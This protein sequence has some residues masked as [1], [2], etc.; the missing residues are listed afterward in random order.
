M[1]YRSKR[2]ARRIA[3]KSR[4]HFIATLIISGL[5]LFLTINWIL[6][7]FINGIG[8]IRQN[9]IKNFGKS[10][11]RI[12]SLSENIILAPP[13]LNIAY[14]ATNTA[15]IDI[16]GYS[17]AGSKVKLFMDDV[18]KETS[19]VSSDGSFIFQNVSLSFGTNNIYSKTA[20]EAG[21]ESLPSKLIKV[22]FDNEKPSLN[23]N[24]PEDGKKIQGGDKKVKV[25]GNSEVGAKVFINEIQ[26]VVDKDGNF[27]TDLSLSDG[28]NTISIKAWDL[29]SNQT[30]VQRRVN[31]TP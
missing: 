19:D 25:S 3:R 26:T 7:T 24:E 29:A 20:D 1:S 2:A 17:T 10:P 4:Y 18:E 12:I 28:D 13:V 15:Q 16:P 9:L 22:I 31:Y 5:L 23:I 11:A 21:K 14:E 8:F 6:P 27:S 30:E